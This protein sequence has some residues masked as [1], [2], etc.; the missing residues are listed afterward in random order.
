MASLALPNE[1][2]NFSMAPH[3]SIIT[4]LL[5]VTKLLPL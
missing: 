3:L 4:K 1:V 5:P 2:R